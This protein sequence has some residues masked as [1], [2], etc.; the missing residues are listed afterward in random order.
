MSQPLLPLLAEPDGVAR[1]LDHP[2][3]RIVDVGR[4]EIYVRTHLPGAVHLDY[5][6]LVHARPPAMGLLPDV[7]TLAETLGGLGITPE[8]HVLAY[9][10]ETNGRAARLL[11]TLD[12]VGH[13]RFSLLNGGLEQWQAEERPVESGE[14]SPTPTC[15]PVNLRA[16]VSADLDYVRDHLH[17]ARTVLLDTRSPEEYSGKLKRAARGGHIPGAVNYNWTDAMDHDRHLRVRPAAELR[18]E[19]EA[20]GVDAAKEIV[21]YCQTHHRSAHTYIV[22]KH[23]GY[24]RVR[25]YAGSWSEWGNRPDTPIE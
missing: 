24:P 14:R 8:H 15:Y 22:L 11:W 1:H 2:Q 23:L 10:D 20:L 7:A 25:G 19:F 3:L 16:E 21:V 6:R 5:E 9:D 4:R 18:R 17:D 13:T 12:A